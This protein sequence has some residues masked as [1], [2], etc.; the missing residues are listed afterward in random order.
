MNVCVYTTMHT[1]VVYGGG[2][3]GG[4]AAA[5]QKSKDA[6]HIRSGGVYQHQ[7]MTCRF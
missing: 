7:D 5:R 1:C 2:G 4:G 3:G 6:K